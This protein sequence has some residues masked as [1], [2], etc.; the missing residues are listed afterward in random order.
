MAGM[1]IKVGGKVRFLNEVG[2]GRDR[3]LV[4]TDEGF[5]IEMAL[6]ELVP[7]TQG[8]DEVIYDLKDHQVRTVIENDLMNDRM[9]ADR[10]KGGSL[11]RAK[12]G[13]RST[14]D[15]VMEI[16]LHLHELVDNEHHLGDAEKLDHQLR[17]F[18]RML[19]TAIR[20]GKRKMIVIH[21]VGEGRLRDEVRRVLEHY[22]VVRFH[23]ANP[24]LYGYGATEVEILRH[25]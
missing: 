20:T 5:E 23:D 7:V 15:S 19:N 24:R 4:R 8:V 16:D 14:D 18:E 1:S 11:K 17:Y 3:A 10:K 25:G 13:D 9:A 21:G 6:K 12:Q 22:D 2:G